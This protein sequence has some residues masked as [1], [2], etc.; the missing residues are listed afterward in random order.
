MTGY[1]QKSTNMI[2]IIRLA[3][4]PGASWVLD[5]DDDISVDLGEHKGRVKT[6]AHLERYQII[7]FKT[8]K[9]GVI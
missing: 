9:L 1:M 7:K 3:K 2:K 8:Q 5:I 6:N 4:T